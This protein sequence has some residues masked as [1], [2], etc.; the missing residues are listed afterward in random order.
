QT[1][2]R[3]GRLGGEI[4]TADG[5]DDEGYPW[6]DTKKF[7][8]WCNTDALHVRNTA[9]HRVADHG[10]VR[11]SSWNPQ[12]KTFTATIT[13]ENEVLVMAPFTYEPVREVLRADGAEIPASFPLQLD[14][15]RTVAAMIG[16]G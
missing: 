14:H 16:Q 15:E 10:Q 4:P 9:Y 7:L 3:A 13:T 2:M 8:A 5:F 1:M 12:Q 11:S 6:W